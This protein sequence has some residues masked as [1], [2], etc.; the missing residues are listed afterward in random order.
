MHGGKSVDKI[1]E[2][3]SD[4]YGYCCLPSLRVAKVGVVLGEGGGN[5]EGEGWSS[6]DGKAR[7]EERPRSFW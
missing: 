7:R 1:S 5:G 4:V 2:D 6:S 3:A